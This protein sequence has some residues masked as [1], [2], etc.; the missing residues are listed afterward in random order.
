MV[1]YIV[2]YL[3]CLMEI[4][5]DLKKFPGPTS[6]SS[7]TTAATMDVNDI[8][9][10]SSSGKTYPSIR[11]MSLYNFSPSNDQDLLLTKKFY[12]L[13]YLYISFTGYTSSNYTT[14]VTRTAMFAYIHSTISSYET[15]FLQ[16]MMVELNF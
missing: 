4:M 12:K 8:G 14:L 10:G 16:L 7:N 5:V 1:F 9:I 2:H 11:G 13:D 15:F 3:P 6:S